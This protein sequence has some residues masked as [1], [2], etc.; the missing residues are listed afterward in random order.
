MT[1]LLTVEALTDKGPGRGALIHALRTLS[2]EGGSAPLATIRQT[3][4][5]RGA[6]GFGGAGDG[7][8][9]AAAEPPDRPAD[10]TVA[11]PTRRDAALLF[12]LS[13]DWNRIHADPAV[14]QAA[15]FARPILQGLA[16]FGMA[17]HAVLTRI[18][19]PLASVEARYSAPVLPGDTLEC[20]IWD[21]G[22]AAMFRVT[23]RS[24]DQVVLE[25]GRITIARQEAGA[26][27]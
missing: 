19:G 2:L 17:T 16:T 20:E 6:G 24:T 8:V 4:F 26:M 9:L 5:C 18:G 13:G 22:A 12:R 10:A 11:L 7:P 27:L 14:A 21:G 23:N 25:R 1:S 3:Y 15:G